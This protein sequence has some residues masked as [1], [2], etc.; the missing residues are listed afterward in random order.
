MTERQARDEGAAQTGI[1]VDAVKQARLAKGWSAAQLADE[2]KAVGVPWNASVVENLEYG[3]RKS[4][5][6][7]EL[8]AL[9]W[10]LE[11][12]SPLDLLVPESEDGDQM[13]PVTPS[14]LV[15]RQAVRGWLL[16]ET[17]P[18]RAWLERT[19]P[20]EPTIEEMAA[21]LADMP[22]AMRRQIVYMMRST[23]RLGGSGGEG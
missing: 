20:D 18:L 19:G 17:G 21:V 11:V 13:Y 2:M 23:R 15:F 12:N 22:P 3:K 1:I 6:V 16:G 4:L 9:A 10:V 5:R 14:I 7:H 8:L